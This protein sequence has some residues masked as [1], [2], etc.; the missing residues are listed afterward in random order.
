MV[1]KK[2]K[3]CNPSGFHLRPAGIFCTEALK[4]DC[5]VTFT[6]RNTTANAKSILSILGARIKEG[7]T[8]EVYCNGTDEEKALN[9]IVQLI[10]TGLEE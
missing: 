6:C 9:N 1:S 7:D 8:I 2:V 4:Y 5:S 10:E 3:I